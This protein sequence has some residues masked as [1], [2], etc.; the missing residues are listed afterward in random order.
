MTEKA[1]SRET[2]SA[3]NLHKHAGGRILRLESGLCKASAEIRLVA[4]RTSKPKQST[5]LA[6]KPT[7]KPNKGD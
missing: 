2:R 4:Y 6:Q 7:P 5:I 3:T 1:D